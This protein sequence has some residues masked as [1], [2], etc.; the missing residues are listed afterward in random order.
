MLSR[1]RREAVEALNQAW[2]RQRSREKRRPERTDV[3]PFATTLYAADN[4]AN[5][6][7]RRVYADHGIAVAEPAMEVAG[8]QPHKGREVMRTRYCLRRELGM[9]LKH[10]AK[11]ESPQ[12]LYLRCDDIRFALS[13]DCKNCEM[14]VLL[15]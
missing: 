9:C 4:V 1:L 10:T 8:E 2:K 6:L 5:H 12:R 3:P 7:A 11:N 15:D 14:S 13:F